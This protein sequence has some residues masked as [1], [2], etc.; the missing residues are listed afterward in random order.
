MSG[1]LKHGAALFPLITLAGL[2]VSGLLL[3]VTALRL[4]VSDEPAGDGDYDERPFLW[5]P[6]VRLFVMTA[7]FATVVSWIGFYPATF[8]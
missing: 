2:F 5:Q 7:L 6:L 1:G 3:L 8:L 4:V